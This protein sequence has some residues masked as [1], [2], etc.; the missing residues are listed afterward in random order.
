MKL[1]Q[2]ALAAA[3]LLMLGPCLQA[4]DDNTPLGDVARKTKIEASKEKPKIILDEY[5]TSPSTSGSSASAASA[6][7]PAAANAPV[8]ASGGASA[9]PA[10]KGDGGYIAGNEYDPDQPAPGKT[11]LETAQNKVNFYTNAV[12]E[13][14]DR[15]ADLQKQ[16]QKEKD[17]GRLLGLKDAVTA[18]TKL[19]NSDQKALEDA[20]AELNQ[21]QENQ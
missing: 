10:D 17:E 5:N 18:K 13:L 14:N 19:L 1:P 8:A 3:A 15:I 21:A 7:G 16:I 11:P 4:Q 9:G 20:K 2:L 12:A 6:T